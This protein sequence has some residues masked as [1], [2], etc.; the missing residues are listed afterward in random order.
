MFCRHCGFELADSDAFCAKCGTKVVIVDETTDTSIKKENDS[1]VRESSYSDDKTVSD[2]TVTSN[3]QQDN[4]VATSK[5][6]FSLNT[7]KPILILIGVVV[8]LSVVIIVAKKA[9]D[10][11]KEKFREE[12]SDKV[13]EKPTAGDK[14]AEEQKQYNEDDNSETIA[15]DSNSYEDAIRKAEEIV[16]YTEVSMGADPQKI[17]FH[18][19]NVEEEDRCGRYLVKMVLSSDMMGGRH[20]MYSVV[21]FIDGQVYYNKYL[22]FVYIKDDGSNIDDINTIKEMNE[23]GKTPSV[24]QP[25]PTEAP[26]PAIEAPT[27]HDKSGEGDYICY[28]SSYDIMN[29]SKWT[30]QR[31]EIMDKYPNLPALPSQMVI[32]EIYAKHGFI[33]SDQKLNDFFAERDWYQGTTDDMNN[34]SKVLNDAEKQN[35]SYLKGLA[36]KKPTLK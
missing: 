20:T 19:A 23:W 35:I 25:Q 17:S 30:K 13:I 9:S 27:V 36:L 16:F 29:D 31:Q 10:A 7:I 2:K 14:N 21:Q 33:F 22:P 1:S 26:N 18:S 5:T 8:I 15:T 3:D 34:I 12:Y 32:N 24:N 4:D 28:W 6:S 11:S